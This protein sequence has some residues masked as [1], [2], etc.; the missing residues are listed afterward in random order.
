MIDTEALRQKVLDLAIRGRLTQQLPE[1][2]T[3]EELYKKIQEERKCQIKIGNIKQVELL[4]MLENCK[5]S[6]QI[7]DNWLWTPFGNISYIIRGGSPR[8]IKQY[9]TDDEKGINWI[10]IGDVEKG[11]KYI[12]STEEKIRP[13]GEKKSRK[14]YP[15]DFLLTN[16]MSF[17]RP[18]ISK[19]EG[20]IHDGWLLIRNLGGF[21]IDYLYYLLS[22][23]YLYNQF[24]DKA[25]GSTV[26]NLNIDK[27]KS[28]N[29]P[30]PPLAEQKRVVE[31][32]ESLF[33]ILDKIDL[34]QSE[35]GNNLIALKSK[36]IEAGIQGKLTEQLPEDGTA[37]ELVLII[38]EQKKKI[39]K[40]GVLK[41]RKSKSLE[42]INE[43]PALSD[44]PNTWKWIRLGE[45]AEIFGRIGFRGYK[46]SDI[47]A[48]GQGAI[49]I[50]PSNITNMGKT[51]FDKCTFISWDKYEESP[52]I[53]VEEQDLLIV[54]TGST[55]GKCGIVNRLPE[56]ATINP[57]LAILKY[58]LCD[59]Y[60]LNYVLNSSFARK[61]YEN[62]VVGAA[63]PTFSQEKLAN[64]IMPLPPLAEQKRIVAKLDEV[65]AIL[66]GKSEE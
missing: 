8:P 21:D 37:E 24:S 32:V 26:T 46:K 53:M 5:L 1:D 19:I 16:S 40:S 39:E 33:S 31:K 60:Y 27:V 29:I 25:S 17:G 3:A 28:A 66:D 30:L 51:V 64:F 62:F 65:L 13:E 22:S 45:V 42:P 47:V 2:G 58:V 36:I 63:V 43:I 14:V 34:L 38:R 50:S 11:G 44:I 4:P 41:G 59:R 48:P 6:F 52:E 18:Y 12:F 23:K 54:K 55:Y 56:K 49:T 35:Y 10:K 61:Q 9:I 15:G 57:Q 20:C 7:P